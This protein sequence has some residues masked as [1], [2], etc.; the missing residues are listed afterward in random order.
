MY[1]LKDKVRQWRSSYLGS[2]WLFAELDVVEMFP[3]IDRPSVPLALVYF[4]THLC[5]TRGLKVNTARFSIHKGGVKAL[6]HVAC[7]GLQQGFYKLSFVD[8][9][10]YA[11]WDL[12]FHDLFVSCSSVFR[13]RQHSSPPLL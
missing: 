13:H 9:M 4:F 1:E 2:A 11:F 12:L 10:R 7:G 6:D 5:D 8:V 3:N